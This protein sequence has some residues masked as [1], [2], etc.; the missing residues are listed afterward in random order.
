MADEEMTDERRWT[1]PMVLTTDENVARAWRYFNE[2]GDTSLLE[3]L[4]LWQA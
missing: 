3:E 4:G 2:T 1:E